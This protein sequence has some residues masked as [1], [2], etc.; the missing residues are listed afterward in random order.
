MKK[1]LTMLLA[2]CCMLTA[3]STPASALEYRFDGP[4]AGTFGRPTS[5]DTIYVTTDEPANTDRS[6]DAAY[7]PPAFGSPT[8]YVPNAGELL[9]PNLVGGAVSGPVS[10]VT[11]LPPSIS[12]S[13][14]GNTGSYTPVKYTAV[15]KDLYYSG[16]YLGT[17]KIP[18]LGLSVKVYQGTDSDALRKGAGH[19]TN[20]SIWEGNVAIAGHNRGV[21]N[22]FGKIHT[23]SIGD[24]IKLTTLLGT[25][26]YE[27]YSVSKISVNDISVLNDSTE[28]IITL[29]TC[30]MNQPD[31]RW[32][33]Q[34]RQK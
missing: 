25:R 21:N 30:V 16:G 29:V 34:V 11:V 10:G 32:C 13:D 33:V 22:H 9:T 12:G 15:T 8:S 31:Y 5:D 26:S 6:K 19:F 7:I 3:F 23:L 27:V 20:T 2:V 18:T 4:D 24:T 28:D 1:S 14:A 17:L